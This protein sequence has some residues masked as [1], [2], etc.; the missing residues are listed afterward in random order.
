[1]IYVDIVSDTICPWCFI[2]KRRFEQALQQLKRDDILVAWRPFQLNPDMPAEGMTRE[3]YLSA[4]FGGDERVRKVYG[5]IA[6]TGRDVGI[7]FHFE[8]IRRTPNTLQ[9][10]R[11]VK[12]AGREN[13]Q[14]QLVEALFQAYFI[15]GRDVGDNAV[16]VDVAV[17]AGLMREDAERYLGSEEDR[18]EVSASD[19]YA[20]RLGINGVPCFIVNRKYA[21]SGA[22]PADAFVQVFEL[23]D[24]EGAEQEP[25]P[26][27]Q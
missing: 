8:R 27:S 1:M 18:D 24:R 22:Q 9:S 10:H 23:A 6:E 13:L 17:Q 2:G 11:L 15:D 14:D 20:R 7:D 19:L 5:A 16:L 3:A 25:Q 12:L 4:K 21:V 26:V